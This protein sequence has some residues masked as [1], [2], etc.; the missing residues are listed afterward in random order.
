MTVW[1]D[2]Y[3]GVPFLKDGRTPSGWDCYGCVRYVLALHAG[4]YLPP[5][6]EA[7]DRSKWIKVEMAQAYDLAE[8]PGLSVVDGKTRVALTHVGMFVSAS[9]L[10]H[11]KDGQDTVCIPVDRLRLPVVAIWRHESMI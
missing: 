4:I 11:C 1:T 7:L 9:R 10:L 2:Q 5:L 3:I 6:P 8:M